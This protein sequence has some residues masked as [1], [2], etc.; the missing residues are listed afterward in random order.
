MEDSG[1]ALDFL[2]QIRKQDSRHRLTFDN[3]MNFLDQK[4]REK[5][6]PLR[7][8]VELTPL[9]NFDCK[10]CYT[11]LTPE[12]MNGKKLL[13]VPEWKR[14]LQAAFEAGM[15]SIN[16]TGGECLTYPGF[17]EIY[18]YLWNLGIEI[19]VLTNGLLLDEKWIRFFQK[20]MPRLI[21]ITLYGSSDETYEQVTGS[22]SFTTVY[23]HIQNAVRAGLPVVLCVTPSKYM[24]EAVFDTVRT[25]HSFG[26]EYTVNSFLTEPKEET[27]RAGGQHDLELDDYVRIFR[28]VN[29]LRQV[30]NRTISLEKLPSPGGTCHQASGCGLNCKAGLSCFTIEWDGRMY[31]CSSIRD[32]W[33]NP[34][35]EGFQTAWN[36][37]HEKAL[38]WP[39]IPECIGCP[40]ESV[41]I[42]CAPFKAKYNG[43]GK[44]PIMLCEQTRYLV[45]KGVMRISDCE[46]TV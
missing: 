44:Q 30:E 35:E 33:A 10:M 29:E 37:I 3:L 21:Q 26:I 42:N 7:G 40:Y 20:H 31:A 34:L 22:R 16:L 6:I 43:K 1:N 13:T 39:V 32:F 9:C 23:Q 46:Y 4:A 25:A 2:D 36:Q 45:H 12:Q 27:G 19:L 15:M 14:L 8:Q 11:H 28:F 18:L 41:C 17:E 5:G 24:G 38:E